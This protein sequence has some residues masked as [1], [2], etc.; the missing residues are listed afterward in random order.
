MRAVA[1]VLAALG[2]LFA[3]CVPSTSQAQVPVRVTTYLPT[4]SP[5]ASGLWPFEGAAACSWNFPMGTVL[6]LHDG[7]VITCLD[8]G[9]LGNGVPYSWVDIF[10]PTLAQASEVFWRY[11]GWSTARVVRWGYGE[12]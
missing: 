2:I 7:L 4:G 9:D 10:L 6:E 11:G 5:M 1:A 3:V 12:G 8:R